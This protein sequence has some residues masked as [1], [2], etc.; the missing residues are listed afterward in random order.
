[1]RR[2]LPC[3]A[4]LLV[5]TTTAA[6]SQA[7]DPPKSDPVSKPLPWDVVSVKPHKVGDDVGSWMR[8]TPAGFSAIVAVRSL[9]M[10]A[11]NLIMLDQVSG[12]PGWAENENFDV[13]GKMD[14]EAAEAFK[15]LSRNDQAYQRRLMMQT[16][17]ADRFKLKVHHD[18]RELP[19]YNL[20]IAKNGVKMKEA[21]QA[22]DY[23]W[24][25]GLG[26]IT[27]KG[28]P[29]ASLAVCLSN[30]V[31]RMIVDKTGLTGKY[32][33]DLTWAWNDDPASGDS[34]PSLFTALQ[35]LR[36]E[37]AKAPIDVVV[38]DHIERPSEN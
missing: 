2:I 35:G 20:L 18:L 33:I 13:E 36:L 21:S 38:I 31:G 37:P 28:M 14:A 34:G 29:I 5:F 6:L 4:I 11:N 26:R 12:L 10:T 24:S 30:P 7:P 15:K 32:E 8:T 22:E 9:I 17:L 16:L 3:V 1:M 19:V 27:S 23:S 25:M